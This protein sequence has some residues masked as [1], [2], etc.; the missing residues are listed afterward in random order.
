MS[1]YNRFTQPTPATLLLMAKQE[2]SR[3]QALCNQKEPKESIATRA[4]NLEWLIYKSLEVGDH[5]NAFLAAQQ[6]M[7]LKYGLPMI[8]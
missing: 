2:R 4:R 5:D 7:N 3:N 8:K 1:L 6:L